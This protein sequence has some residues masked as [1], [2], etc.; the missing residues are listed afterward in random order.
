ML[1]LEQTVAMVLTRAY[2][3]GRPEGVDAW[4]MLVNVKIAREQLRHERSDLAPIRGFALREA[5]LV[6][7]VDNDAL[8][9]TQIPIS[10]LCLPT[11]AENW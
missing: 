4:E 2:P 11:S 5:T 7:L 9:T 6:V 3:A 10:D 8:G 1:S